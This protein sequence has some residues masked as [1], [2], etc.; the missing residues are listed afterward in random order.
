MTHPTTEERDRAAAASQ[1]RHDLITPVNHILGFAELLIE[2]AEERGRSHLVDR[3]G[4]VRTL[5]KQVLEGI[6]HALAQASEVGLPTDLAG[7]GL[8]LLGPCGSITETCDDIEGA[9]GQAPDRAFFLGDLAK[10]RDAASRLTAIAG[11]LSAPPIA[12]P[13]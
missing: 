8:A 10:V 4:T 9:V 12:P 1:L 6:D 2:E 3:L 11:R 7:L 5:G 13:E